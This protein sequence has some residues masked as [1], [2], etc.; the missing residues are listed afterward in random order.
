M[1]LRRVVYGIKGSW[2]STQH[3]RGMAW[4]LLHDGLLRHHPRVNSASA[5]LWLYDGSAEKWKLCMYEWVW[6]FAWVRRLD[7]STTF[8]IVDSALRCRAM[9]ELWCLVQILLDW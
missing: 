6:R 3:V 7:K 4:G 2:R 5:S 1:R 8:E 9:S